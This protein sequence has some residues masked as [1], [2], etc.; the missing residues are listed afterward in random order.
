MKKRKSQDIFDEADFPINHLRRGILSGT[1]VDVAECAEKPLI[2]VANSA[3]DINPGH[4]H[5]SELA[6]LVKEGINAGGGIPFEFNVPAPCDGLAEGNPGMRYILPQRDLIA[7]IVE[8][9]IQSMR[10][11]AVVMIASCDKIL[12]GMLMAAARLDLPVIFLTGGPN[13]MAIRYTSAYKGS[14]SPND[15]PEAA[16]KLNCLQSASCGACEIIGTANTF[17]CL[18]ES[19][20][21]CLP[22]SAAVPAFH[23]DRKRI[24][25]RTGTR[26]VKMVE[27]DITARKL[28]TRKT[29]ENAVI[30]CQAIGGSTNAALHL[31]AL[32]HDLDCE[33][34]L[35]TF[36][37]LGEKVPTLLGI[38][39]NGPYGMIDFHTAGG[40][41]GVMKRLENDLHSDVLTCTGRTLGDLLNSSQVFDDT[42]IP[43]REH[44]YN[45]EAGTVALFGNL[46][47]EGCVVKQSAVDADMKVFSGMARVFES[48]ADAL[49][50]L[51]DNNIKEGDVLVIRNEGPKGGPGMPETLAV[52]LH[53]T[54]SGYQKVAMITDGRF[55]GATAGPCVGHISPEAADGGPIAAIRNGDTISINIPDKTIEVQLSDQEIKNRLDGWVYQRAKPLAGYMKRYVKHVVSASKGAYLD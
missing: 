28:L 53:L 2:A 13:A 18:T 35:E 1:G 38:V 45:P 31:P 48:E 23:A 40:I 54:M 11:D 19:L 33:I 34:G 41:P 24:A 27:E 46:S 17:Q 20:G 30:V 12:P 4:A 25:R 42:V 8:M 44:P 5:L 21:M 47:P 6:G 22:G 14:I 16:A 52:T 49:T 50:A 29:L 15:Q 51:R 7:E 36:N 32:A 10:F 43:H 9:H 39:P 55:S 3:T 37:R 26:V